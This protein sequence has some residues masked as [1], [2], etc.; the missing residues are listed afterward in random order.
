MK[1]R[2]SRRMHLIPVRI[3]YCAVIFVYA[4]VTNQMFAKL[5]GTEDSHA[6]YNSCMLVQSN[7]LNILNIFRVKQE[8]DTAKVGN[9]TSIKYVR[10][11]CT[12]NIKM[13]Y[14]GC[15]KLHHFILA[16]EH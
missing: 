9:F 15:Y 6:Q 12:S 1:K 10:L 14:I 7:D 2:T 4:L 13:A 5:C 11:T 16:R 3:A 8:I